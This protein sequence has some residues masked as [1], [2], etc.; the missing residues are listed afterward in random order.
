MNNL[1]IRRAVGVAGSLA[2][3]MLFSMPSASAET[4]S[5]PAPIEAVEG[6]IEI[7]YTDIEIHDAYGQ[8][9]FYFKDN[10]DVFTVCDTKADGAGVIGKLW[11]KPIGGDWYVAASEDDGGDAGCDKFASDVGPVGDYQMKLYWTGVGYHK[12][13]AKSRVFNE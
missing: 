4:D 8:G 2:A 13:I 12:E 7:L 1:L 5:V 10:G 3:V 9:S 6:D 11:Y